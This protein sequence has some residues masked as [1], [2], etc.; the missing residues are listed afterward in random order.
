MLKKVII[1]IS[2]IVVIIALLF[3]PLFPRLVL[4]SVK[5]NKVNFIFNINKKEF[6]ISYTHSVNKGR[7]RDYY[8][9][10]TNNDIVL[11]KTRFVSYGAGMSDPQND[12]NIIITDDYIEINNIKKQIKDLYLF[13]GIVADHRIEL[14]GN[15]KEIKLNTLFEPQVN[16]KIQYKRVSLFTIII[17]IINNKILRGNNET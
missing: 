10:N 14:G 12:E 5:N 4:N 13:V 16:I 2:V 9:I 11:D 7:I 17:N 8:I 3:I 1:C 6:L 15:G